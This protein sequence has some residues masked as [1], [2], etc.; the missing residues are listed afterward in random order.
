MKTAQPPQPAKFLNFLQNGQ[1][2]QSWNVPNAHNVVETRVSSLAI[3]QSFLQMVG[4][5]RHFMSNAG[6][7]LS[8]AKQPKTKSRCGAWV[9]T[10]HVNNLSQKLISFCDR[11]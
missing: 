4:I 11:T 6:I 1:G 5:V 3:G 2:Y 9:D 10:H 7:A 8:C